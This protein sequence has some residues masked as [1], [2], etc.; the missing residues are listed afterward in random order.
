MDSSIIFNPKGFIPRQVA[1][2]I[3]VH[4]YG[5]RFVKVVSIW[6][7]YEKY[8]NANGNF[9]NESLTDLT[10]LWYLNYKIIINYK[11]VESFLSYS[12]NIMEIGAH[13]QGLEAVGDE[14]FGT[15]GYVTN[16]NG[17]L[18]RKRKFPP[19]SSLVAQRQQIF[20]KNEDMNLVT[21]G[22]YMRV[23]YSSTMIL[24]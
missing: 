3:S 2:N 11:I 4:F 1:F 6:K 19:K 12:I 21:G 17:Y 7:L 22:L 14:L 10:D 9:L 23:I 20:I 5:N 16:S 18:F 24:N 13:A 15:D 8:K